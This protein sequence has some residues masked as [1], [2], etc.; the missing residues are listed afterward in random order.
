M[1]RVVV[2][3]FDVLQKRSRPSVVVDPLGVVLPEVEVRLFHLAALGWGAALLRAVLG[4][5]VSA[6][7][8]ERVPQDRAEAVD[9]YGVLAH[10]VEHRARRPRQRKAQN[11]RRKRHSEDFV[12]KQSCLVSVRLCKRVAHMRVVTGAAPRLGERVRVLCD[13]FHADLGIVHQSLARRREAVARVFRRHEAAGDGV[14][15]RRGTGV[16]DE[17][18]VADSDVE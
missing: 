4:V 13:G 9:V 15:G 16:P 6:K 18:A 10:K 11:Q 7:V 17:V 12:C 1:H 14:D 2:R 8:E 3:R 5:A